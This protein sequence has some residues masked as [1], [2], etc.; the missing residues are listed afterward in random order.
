[1]FGVLQQFV[2]VVVVFVLVVQGGV[3]DYCQWCIFGY[4]FSQQFGLDFCE[5]G[6]VYVDYQCGIVVCQGFLG[7]WVV[8]LGM[9]GYQGYVVVD[10][11]VGQWYI[12]GSGVS[13]FG[14]DVVYYFVVYFV[15]GQL[16]GFFVGVVEDV[17]IV[18]FQVYYV[19]FLVGMLQYQVLD[20]VL[21]CGV[22]VVVFVDLDQLGGWIVFQYVWVDQIV[23]YYYICVLQG[24]NCFQG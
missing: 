15:L 24:V 19:V 6:D 2:E 3:F 20:E 9:C 1:M 11:V 12:V 5:L 4:V 21:W 13:Q 8:V 18:V 14:G 23:D 17:W 7:Q 10:V 16:F 22:V